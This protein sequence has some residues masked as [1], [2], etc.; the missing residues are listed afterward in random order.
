MKETSLVTQH[1][2]CEGI[3]SEGGVLKVDINKT[4]LS[5][6]TGTLAEYSCVLEEN[7][8]TQVPG[9]KQKQ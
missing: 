4:L 1:I 7:K 3:Q 8:K 9:K 2:A 6:M 5:F